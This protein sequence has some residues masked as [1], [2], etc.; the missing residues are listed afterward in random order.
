V[1]FYPTHLLFQWLPTDVAQFPVTHFSILYANIHQA[2][3]LPHHTNRTPS[4]NISYLMINL[5]EPIAAASVEERDLCVVMKVREKASKLTLDPTGW[6]WEYRE[7]LPPEFIAM[8]HRGL[9]EKNVFD[10]LASTFSLLSQCPLQVHIRARSIITALD[11]FG[12]LQ[13]TRECS[14]T[15]GRSLIGCTSG[16]S[17][18]LLF[19]WPT[20]M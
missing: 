7:Q 8:S 1:D 11:S 19:I 2:F 10:G 16:L 9:G 13:T 14:T 4:E 3:F 15:T 20:R 18:G 12:L 6:E 5:R 17:S